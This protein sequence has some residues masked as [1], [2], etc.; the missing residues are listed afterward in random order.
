MTDNVGVVRLAT[1]G[2]APEIMACLRVMHEENGLFAFSEQRVRDIIDLAV[3]PRPEVP[4]PPMIGVIGEP[5]DIQATICLM[6]TNLYY[7]DDY[8]LGDMWNFIRPDC[9]KKMYIDKLLDFAKSCA[10]KTGFKLMTAVVSNKR[11]AAKIRLYE[12]HFGPPVGA[13]FVY[14]AP[15]FEVR[16]VA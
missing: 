16:E 5:D 6:L 3:N 4:I 2:D 7:T 11:T 12:R 15:K 8:H 13:F 1:V 9:R 14:P 10:D